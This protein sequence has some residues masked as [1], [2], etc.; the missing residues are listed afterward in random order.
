[1]YNDKIYVCFFGVVGVCLDLRN[2]IR[3]KAFVGY[4]LRWEYGTFN[5]L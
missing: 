4:V 1:M 2:V 5:D 3:F